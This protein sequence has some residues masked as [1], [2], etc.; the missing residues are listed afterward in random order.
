MKGLPFFT[1][2]I[3][4]EEMNEEEHMKSYADRVVRVSVDVPTT[5]KKD[6]EAHIPYGLLSTISRILFTKLTLLFKE[7]G[8][9]E[10]LSA[11]LNDRILVTII[12]RKEQ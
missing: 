9:K 2:T 4:R 5:L 8:T 11:L 3:S 7:R 10:V 1:L 6:L 12:E